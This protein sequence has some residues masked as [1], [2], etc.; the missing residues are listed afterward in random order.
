MEPK[1]E[2]PFFIKKVLGP[3]IYQL[4]LL[5][6][7]K[8]HDVFYASLLTLYQEMEQHGESFITLPPILIDGHKEV[9]LDFAVHAFSFTVCL[10]MVY[11]EHPLVNAENS[12][13]LFHNL[14]VE[15]GTSI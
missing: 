15:L 3:L 2:G 7:M 4:I 1:H 9:R 11:C 13:D 10:W 12:T 6:W 14:R 5:V 8:C